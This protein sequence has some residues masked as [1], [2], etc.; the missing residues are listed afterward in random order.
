MAGMSIDRQKLQELLR[1]FR[2]LTGICISFWYHGDEWSVIGDTVYASPF[3]ALLRQ[4]ETL[5]HDC[6]YC[7]ARGLNHARETGE[8]CRLVCHAGLHEYT[9]PVQ[10][11]GRTL[12]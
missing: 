11:A 6:E 4:N 5:R 12:G 10:E 8:V 7:D 3:C 2:T 1:D 9:Y